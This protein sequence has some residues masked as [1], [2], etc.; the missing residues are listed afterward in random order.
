MLFG[1]KIHSHSSA[2]DEASFMESSAEEMHK[3]G[4]SKIKDENIYH[5]QSYQYMY[6]IEGDTLSVV[7]HLCSQAFTRSYIARRRTIHI[8]SFVDEIQIRKTVSVT[9]FQVVFI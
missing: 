5:N 7:H 4:N 8:G 6:E 9:I 1:N 3:S 2:T